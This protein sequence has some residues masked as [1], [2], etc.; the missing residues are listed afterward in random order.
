VNPVNETQPP[1]AYCRTCGLGLAQE[2]VRTVSGV[3]YCEAH[4]AAAAAQATPPP[5]SWTAAP[6]A[7]PSGPCPTVGGS[8]GVA[9]LLGLIPG[10]GAIYNGQYV[11]GFIHVLIVGLLCSVASAGVGG[12]EP[13]FAML[14]P[15]W[16]FYMA[17]EAYHTA[18]KKLAGEPVDEYSSVFPLRGAQGFPVAP[19]VL[20][21]TGLLFLLN[22]LE[23]IRIRQILPYIGP[24]FLIALGVYLLYLRL[25]GESSPAPA[26]GAM[27]SEVSHDQR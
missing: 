12:L 6:S 8:P 7:P 23:I 3:I 25:A 16:W 4:A 27:P 14:I 18:K 11:K 1:V 24:G 21:A 15:V 22:N 20:I 9:F 17:F 19:V 2:A 10:V 5:P 13:L 26:S